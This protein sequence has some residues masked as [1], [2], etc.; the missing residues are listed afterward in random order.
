[1]KAHYFCGA[2]TFS[3]KMLLHQALPHAVI[4]KCNAPGKGKVWAELCRPEVS[5]A[6]SNLRPSC[7]AGD[8][9]VGRSSYSQGGTGRWPVL[10][11]YQPDRMARTKRPFGVLEG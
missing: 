3:M 1:M 9:A 10:S 7:R 5:L 2:S 6:S 8:F 11:G 4:E